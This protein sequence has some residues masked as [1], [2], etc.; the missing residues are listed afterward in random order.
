MVE[1][2][3]HVLGNLMKISNMIHV[4]IVSGVVIL[5]FM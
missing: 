1:M 5:Y 2:G 3:L 4:V